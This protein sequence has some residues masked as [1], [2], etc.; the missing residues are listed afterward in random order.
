[1]GSNLELGRLGVFKEVDEL[2]STDKS[3]HDSDG[4]VARFPSCEV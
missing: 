2:E 1:M 3:G 4:D